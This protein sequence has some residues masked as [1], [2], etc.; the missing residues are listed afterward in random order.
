MERQGIITDCCFAQSR[1]PFESVHVM[2]SGRQLFRLASVV[3]IAVLSSSQPVEGEFVILSQSA[4][5]SAADRS[6]HF[7]ITFNRQPE[8]DRVDGFGNPLDSFQYWYDSMPNVADDPFT[9]EDIAVIRGPEIR[10]DQDIPIRDSLNPA[11]KDFP[12]AEG[13][14]RERGAAKFTLHGQTIDFSVPWSLLDERDTKFSYR[15]FAFDA[16]SLTSDVGAVFIPLP[17]AAWMGAGVLV[18]A[19][20]TVRLYRHII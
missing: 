8:F 16:G 10:F 5:S 19:A 17:D 18:F 3:L 20:L 7:S 11:G 9:G 4:S 15:L 14:G 1:C 12:H 6:V 13:W 2:A